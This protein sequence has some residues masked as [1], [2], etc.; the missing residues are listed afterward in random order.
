MVEQKLLYPNRWPFFLSF[1]IAM[2]RD[3]YILDLESVICS[4]FLYGTYIVEE[5]LLF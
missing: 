2:G 4:I 1:T 3:H 5:D